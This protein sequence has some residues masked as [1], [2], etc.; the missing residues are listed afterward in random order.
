MR[1]QKQVQNETQIRKKQKVIKNDKD[2]LEVKN[3]SENKQPIS[4]QQTFNTPACPSC[5]RNNWLG[6]DKRYYCQYC[7]NIINK[8]KHRI[9]K[10]KFVDKIIIFLPD[11]LMLIKKI[12]NMDEYG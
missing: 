4:Q 9:D 10:K 11:C 12:R 8:Q 1:T 3:Q 5:K 7:E 6:F 2:E